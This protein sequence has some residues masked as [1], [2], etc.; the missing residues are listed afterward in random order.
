MAQLTPR[1]PGTP[2]EY[3][4]VTRELIEDLVAV[5]VIYAEVSFGFLAPQV[6]DDTLFWPIMEAMECERREA[7]RRFPIQI[8]FIAGLMRTLSVELAVFHTQ[9]AVQARE[10]GIA[11]VG[12]DL[13]GDEFLS[14]PEPFAPAYDLA[15]AHGLG[16][17]AHAGEAVG[18]ASMWGA[19]NA[20]GVSRVAHGIHALEDPALI[21]RLQRG[22]ITLEICPT[23]NVRTAVVPDLASHPVRRLHDLGVPVT[24]HSDD[25]L[26]FFT[27]IERE[28]RLLVEYFGFS[29]QEL[30]HLTET[31]ARAAFLQ[32]D[33]RTR[34]LEQIAGSWP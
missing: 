21:A 24:V 18:P 34:L 31:A 32:T 27:T 3:A 2:E 22:D 13:H 20:L 33:E 11:I 17:R 29:S 1:L 9:L 14:P 6:G 10:R 7:E 4:R 30:R 8:S 26:P 16:L 5:G 25:P 23:S 19:I 28:L 12:I 15:R